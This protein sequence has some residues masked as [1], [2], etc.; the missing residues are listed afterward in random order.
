MAP[1]KSLNLEQA[2]WDAKYFN[3]C[4]DILDYELDSG[5]TKAISEDI[6]VMPTFHPSYLLR[7]ESAKRLVWQD[8]QKVMALLEK[9]R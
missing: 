2:N 1:P 6:P 7:N 5:A 8:I 3:D 9:D 4:F